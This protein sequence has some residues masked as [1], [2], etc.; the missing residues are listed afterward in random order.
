[1][2]GH[3]WDAIAKRAGLP[4]DVTTH[5]LRHSFASE[6]GDA[7][8]TEL[9]I[10]VLLGHKKAPSPRNTCTA[11]IAFCWPLRTMS[12]SA[13]RSLGLRRPRRWLSSSRGA[14]RERNPDREATAM[15]AKKKSAPPKFEGG[16]A[17][18]ILSPLDMSADGQLRLGPGFYLVLE[19]RARKM[20]AL[21][22]H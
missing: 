5:T 11:P 16:L 2:R 15:T 9:T 18:P 6:A 17:K 8:Y 20:A 3:F 10:S 22:K 7:G 14:A 4:K 21:A 13:S 19:A 1:M 12:P